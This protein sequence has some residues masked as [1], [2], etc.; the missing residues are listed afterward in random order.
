MA[1]LT[2]LELTN[3]SQTFGKSEYAMFLAQTE[4]NQTIECG[5]TYNSLT[6]AQFDTDA[7]DSLLG[8][9][10]ITKEYEDNQTGELMNPEDRIQM[11]L[12]GEAKLVLFNSI[13]SRIKKSELYTSVQ[14]DQRNSISAKVK[15]EFLKEKK[16]KQL[17]AS[18]ERLRAKAIASVGGGGKILSLKKEETLDDVE[19]DDNDIIDENSEMSLDSKEDL[20]F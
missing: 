7:L 14:A 12:D 20:G 17:Q 2:L 9:Q 1:K 16:Q 13:N 19:D 4:D 6:R 8:C 15:V 18:L 5:I 10:I 11:I 3:S